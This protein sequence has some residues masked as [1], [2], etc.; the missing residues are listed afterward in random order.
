MNGKLEGAAKQVEWDINGRIVAQ[1]IKPEDSA[2]DAFQGVHATHLLIILD[3]ANGVSPAI[4]KAAL[5]LAT[6]K[7]S[8]MVA[9]GNPD[10]PHSQFASTHR[11]GSDWHKIH[12][13]YS[14]T[15]N[16][17]KEHVP[18][19]IAGNLI[20]PEW[21]K[22]ARGM[23][24]EDTPMWTSKVLGEFPE[25]SE[26]SL[27]KLSHAI[28]AANRWDI[29]D[30]KKS[31]STPHALGVDVARLGLD[32]TII[33]ERKGKQAGIF[34]EYRL[35]D[36]METTGLVI[37][38]LRETG[39]EN[40]AIDADGLGSGV[41]DRLVEQGFQVQELRGGFRSRDPEHFANKRAEWYWGLRK[42]FEDGD[43]DIPY[44]EEL[45]AQLTAL[46]WKPNSR[47]QIVIES[48]EDMRSRGLP[49]PDKADALAYSFAAWEGSWADAYAGSMADYK[50]TEE[51]QGPNPWFAAYGKGRAANPFDSLKHLGQID[52][53]GGGLPNKRT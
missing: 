38:A 49:S 10:D 7:H 3:E 42:R 32:K 21:I 11:L 9:I 40:A 27:V 31:K 33:M 23:Y 35:R 29:A 19:K 50:A 44:D 1:G 53:L 22:D 17:T 26:D 28:A 52:T 13:G 47:G 2:G 6:G 37:N 18:E 12:I 24:G 30:F 48:K 39:A 4:W 41:Y 43:I 14:D 25:E 8:R 34:A 46:K 16:F 36:T 5:S 45:L 51:P 20:G 15:P